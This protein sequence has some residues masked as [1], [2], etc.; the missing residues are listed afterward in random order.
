MIIEIEKRGGTGHSFEIIV[1]PDNPVTFVNDPD[2]GKPQK[3]FFDGDG[4]DRIIPDSVKIELLE[5]EDSA[6][7]EKANA[8][9][10]AEANEEKSLDKKFV[11]EIEL[12]GRSIDVNTVNGTYIRR[13]A[14][15]EDRCINF[16]MGMNYYAAGEPMYHARGWCKEGE[17]CVHNLMDPIDFLCTVVHEAFEGF[18]GMSIVGLSYDEAHDRFGNVFE[19]KA[20]GFLVG[21]KF[22]YGPQPED[23]LALWPKIMEAIAP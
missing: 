9:R 3:F 22:E 6:N 1:D 11:G 4:S 7:E 14:K 10:A 2:S 15:G 21:E 23:W 20:G 12:H 13:F 8:I 18:E 5:I 16:T 19:E 17:V